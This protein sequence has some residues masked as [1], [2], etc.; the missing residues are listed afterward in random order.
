MVVNIYCCKYL[1]SQGISVSQELTLGVRKMINCVLVVFI[2]F[3]SPPNI[4]Q[5]SVTNIDTNTGQ[6][7]PSQPSQ[8]LLH[9]DQYSTMDFDLNIND[10][11]FFKIEEKLEKMLKIYLKFLSSFSRV[12]VTVTFWNIHQC[13]FTAWLHSISVAWSQFNLN[14]KVSDAGKLLIFCFVNRLLFSIIMISAAKNKV[15]Y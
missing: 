7:P 15:L 14:K 2:K 4:Y 3:Q 12:G 13:P 8:L 1:I 6:V 11:K 10:F 5:V 9:T